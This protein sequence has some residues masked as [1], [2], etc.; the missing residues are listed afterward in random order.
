[1]IPLGAFCAVVATNKKWKR[2]VKIENVVSGREKRSRSAM[3][4]SIRSLGEEYAGIGRRS[5]RK[6]YFGWDEASRASGGMYS[7]F[8]SQ[9]A[10]KFPQLSLT[11]LRVCSLVKA[12][13]PSWR[14]AEILNIS[15]KA[16]E[17]Y[18]VKIRRKIGCAGERLTNMLT[19]I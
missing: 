9:L 10:T 13:L 16:V 14:I 18:R 5:R 6:N 4:R 7:Q 3:V 19:K 11:E 1:M 2:E 17:N 15:E 12:M 8:L